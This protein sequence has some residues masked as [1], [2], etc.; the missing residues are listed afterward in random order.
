MLLNQQN[1]THFF[2]LMLFYVLPLTLKTRIVLSPHHHLL[3]HYKIFYP[4]GVGIKKHLHIS[5]KKVTVALRQKGLMGWHL[6]YA[7]P[8][9]SSTSLCERDRSANIMSLS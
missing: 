4:L 9:A 6:H 1:N 7:F 3:F 8:L 5:K 2:S